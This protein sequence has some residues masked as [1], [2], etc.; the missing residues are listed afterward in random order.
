[1][2]L[3]IWTKIKRVLIVLISSIFIGGLYYSYILIPKF[4]EAYNEAQKEFNEAKKQNTIALSKVKK[5]AIGTPEYS[6]YQNALKVKK[7]KY[8]K[9]VKVINDQKFFEF[10]SFHFFWEKFGSN[11][12]ILIFA[13][14]VLVNTFKDRKRLPEWRF[15]SRV[16]L[17]TTFMSTNMFTYFWIFQEF[18]D[19]SRA[20]YFGLTLF[21]SY[22]LGFVVY[23][24]LKANESL[25]KSLKKKLFNVS[26]HAMINCDEDRVDEMAK[27]I[28]QPL[29]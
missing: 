18:Q 26:Y 20:T 25:V 6:E 14:W 27:V 1:M 7:E 4:S 9:Y 5:L 21:L 24:S 12:S 29:K 16:F 13:I 19:F 10:D 8:N 17:I 22:S 23:F 15:N 11:T 28:N 2:T 3:P